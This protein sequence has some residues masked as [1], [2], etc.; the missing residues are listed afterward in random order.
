MK[1]IMKELISSEGVIYCL[2]VDREGEIIDFLGKE[3]IDK[4]LVSALVAEVVSE[5][6]KQIN[7]SEDFSITAMGEKGIIFFTA[8]K[9][10]ILALLAGQE[11]DTGEIRLKLQQGA[12]LISEM[13]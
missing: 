13:L 6:K 12:R 1:K 5:I 7:I 3:E 9:D 4:T 10:F 11:V 2:V 8:R